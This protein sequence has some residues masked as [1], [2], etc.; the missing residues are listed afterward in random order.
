MFPNVTSIDVGQ[1]LL[2][3][4]DLLNKLSR[5]IRFIALF[6]IFSGII[7][8]AAGV[9]STRYQRIREVVLLKTLG[10]TRLQIAKIQAAEF[11]IIGSA[12]GLT[13]GFLAAVAAHYLLGKLLH[14]EFEF[15]WIPLLSA[16]V[17]T[18]AISIATGWLASRGV[19]KHKPLE[20]LREN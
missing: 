16:T 11:L 6:A 14:T 8:L 13:G 10:G 12:A 18:A 17:G 15:Q 20:I 19:L 1:V 7:I 5:I 3:V 9:V 2:R 4:Q